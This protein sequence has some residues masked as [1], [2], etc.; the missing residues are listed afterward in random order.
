MDSDPYSLKILV[1]VT[2]EVEAAAVQGALAEQG[3]DAVT[4][5]GFTSGFKAEAPGNVAVQVREAD[6]AR[7][8]AILRELRDDPQEIDWSQVDVG[9]PE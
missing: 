1:R 2:T 4:T 6:V 9:K 3:I 7:A 5:G 8:R